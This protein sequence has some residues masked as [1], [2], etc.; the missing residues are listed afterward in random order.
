LGR[1]IAQRGAVALDL[2]PQPT[3]LTSLQREGFASVRQSAREEP[4]GIR[5]ANNW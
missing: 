3:I 2:Y 4:V 5:A 1:L